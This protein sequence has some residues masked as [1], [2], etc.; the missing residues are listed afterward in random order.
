MCM[1][2]LPIHVHVCVYEYHIHEIP[3]K[4]GRGSESLELK[5]PSTYGSWKL[6]PVPV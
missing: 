3:V 6:K 4:A 1:S 5:W 2:I